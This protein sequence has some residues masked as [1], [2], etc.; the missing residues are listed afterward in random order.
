MITFVLKTKG[1][2]RPILQWA[3]KQSRKF[4]RLE[5]AE[6]MADYFNLSDEARNELTRGDLNRIENRT[7]LSIT[8]LK[9]AELLTQ[10]S[11]KSCEITQ[12]G[13]DEA[14]SSYE[15]MTPAYLENKFPA[16][17]RWKNKEE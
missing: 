11:E 15:R 6:A 4:T 10:P 2:I 3:S 1:F 14:F 13:R 16:Y 12:V 17:W 9:A 8:H 7:N 5:A